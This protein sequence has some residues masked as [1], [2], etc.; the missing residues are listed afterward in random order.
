MAQV[1][2]GQHRLV[3]GAEWRPAGK[4]LVQQ[5]ADDIDVGSGVYLLT[6]SLLGRKVRD[7]PP[8]STLGWRNSM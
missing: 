6:G 2:Q 5:A 7:A 3:A 1:L 4:H 8:R